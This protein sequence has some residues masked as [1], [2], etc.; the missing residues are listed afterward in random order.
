LSIPLST[1]HPEIH[2]SL[3]SFRQDSQAA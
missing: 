2:W 3:L 1:Q